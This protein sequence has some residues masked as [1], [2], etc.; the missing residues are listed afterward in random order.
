[1][2]DEKSNPDTNPDAQDSTALDALSDP[3]Y[4][5]PCPAC[6][7]PQRC[8][9]DNSYGNGVNWCLACGT[10][11]IDRSDNDGDP[12]E[13][14]VLRPARAGQPPDPIEAIETIA[15][16]LAK[17][18]DPICVAMFLAG[19]SSRVSGLAPATCKDCGE[20]H[21]PDEEC[22]VDDSDD[23]IDKAIDAS[24]RAEGKPA[25]GVASHAAE[26]LSGIAARRGEELSAQMRP[27]FEKN[28][29]RPMTQAEMV[30]MD[31]STIVAVTLFAKQQAGGRI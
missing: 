29:G 24:R 4:E 28:V 26:A 15:L 2:T 13:P 7:G 5:P 16:Q 23:D 14:H 31:L 20:P 18:G 19:L 9:G 12:L 8:F 25:I 21:E 1:M 17:D 10:L 6:G 22:E 11:T 30:L 3:D 27:L